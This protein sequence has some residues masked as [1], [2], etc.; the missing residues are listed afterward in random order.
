MRPQETNSKPHTLVLW[1]VI[2]AFAIVFTALALNRHAAF[3]SN[4]FDLG[5]VNQAIWNTAHGRPF[6]FTNMAPLSNRLALHVEPI[7][8]LFVPFYWLGIGGPQLL[9]VVQALIVALGAWPLYL[10]ARPKI[11]ANG[12]LITGVAYL[13]YPAL[14]A[15]VL[16]DFHAVTLAP[17]FLLFAFY[18]LEQVFSGQRSAVSYQR[19]AVSYQR[20][21]VSSQRSASLPSS[22]FRLPP[23]AFLLHPSSFILP[24]SAFLFLLLALSCKEDMGFVVAMLGLYFGLRYK[25]WKLAAFIFALG[26]GWSLAAI[27]LIQPMFVT[28]GNIQGARYAWLV[29]ALGNPQLLWLHWQQVNLP[30]YLWR[31]FAPVAGLSLLSPLALLPILPSLAINLLSSHPLTWRA[32]EFHYAAP[33]APFVFIAAAQGIGLVGRWAGEQ[34]DRM[35]GE[36]GRNSLFTIHYSLF[37]ILLLASLSYHYFHGFTPLARPFGWRPVAAHQRLGAEMAAQIDPALPLFAPL[38]LNSHVSS[39]AVLHQDFANIA[40]DDWLWLDVSTLPNE[41]NIQ[42]HIRDD[43]LPNYKIVSASDGYLL[44]QPN[45]NSQSR[46]ERSRSI[47]IQNLQFLSFALAAADETPQ[48]PLD[49]QFG[50]SLRLVGYD[51]HFNRAETEQVTTYWQALQPLPPDISPLLFLADAEGNLQGVTAARDFS[52]ALIWFPPDRWQTGQTV[53]VRFN[54]LTWDTRNQKTY[55]LGI[56]VSTAPDPW[57]VGARWR[58]VMQQSPYANRLLSERTVLELAQFKRAAG[59]PEGVP[60]LRQMSWPIVQR[61]LK[62]VFGSQ[63]RLIGCN[64]PQI[65]QANGKTTLQLD[66]FW[67][68]LGTE[69]GDYTRFVHVLGPN[70]QMWGQWDSAPD[71]GL[72]PTSLWAEGEF[73][74]ERVNVPLEP[75]AQ[76]GLYTLRVGWYNPAS[77]ARLLTPDGQDYIEISVKNKH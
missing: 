7:L 28:G 64:A 8:F 29:D 15:A 3:E 50:D 63:I 9:L 49:V 22:V 47:E 13:L 62:A 31:L 6:A 17:T 34:V 27:L 46:A 76:T 10:I 74:A 54:K 43:L 32:E 19:S 14:E 4:G 71:G 20:S 61:R 36:Q 69:R 33:M 75:E 39:R 35:A 38:N 23:S 55:R 40:P 56:G 58:P 1:G 77:G 65:H 5:N 16:F 2:I 73:V 66:L 52:P 57:N 11:G 37:T 45:N 18:F 60:A 70:G 12:A 26:M 44:L 67:Q 24:P 25:R 72:Y 48:Y 68:G 51:I 41:N 42:Q 21:A 30:N 59:M 53:K